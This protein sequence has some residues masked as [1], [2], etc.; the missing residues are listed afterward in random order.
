MPKRQPRPSAGRPRFREKRPPG[1]TPVAWQDWR[2][3]VASQL[4]QWAVEGAI[5]QAVLADLL[6]DP[7]YQERPGGVSARWVSDLL[8]GTLQR[9]P[10]P[11]EF[12]AYAFLTRHLF[13]P[14][15]EKLGTA[16]GYRLAV[17]AVDGLREAYEEA[18]GEQ[19]PDQRRE[20]LGYLFVRV[21]EAL[22]S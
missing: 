2:T 5:S 15:L 14:F 18:W 9:M 16:V 19:A 7:E 12:I 3:A 13:D 4:S 21:R 17:P 10:Y 20:M 11:L 22:C 8:R 1:T 6:S